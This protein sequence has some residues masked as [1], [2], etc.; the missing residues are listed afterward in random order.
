M[1]FLVLDTFSHEVRA[2]LLQFIHSLSLPEV[3]HNPISPWSLAMAHLCPPLPTEKV[4]VSLRLSTATWQCFDIWQFQLSTPPRVAWPPVQQPTSEAAYCC[5]Y[6]QKFKLYFLLSLGG[7][8]EML[9]YLPI[10]TFLWGRWK[11]P[12]SYDVEWFWISKGIPPSP[13]N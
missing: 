5:Y 12:L 1:D 6:F 2:A 4:S 3:S 9:L 11:W 8:T 7:I 13:N 10:W